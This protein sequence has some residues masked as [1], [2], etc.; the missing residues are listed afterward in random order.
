MAKYVIIKKNGSAISID[1]S[2]PAEEQKLSAFNYGAGG[3]KF[4]DDAGE[5]HNMNPDA[6]DDL[7]KIP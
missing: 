4:T 5:E 7:K 3:L 1:V 6:I 2:T